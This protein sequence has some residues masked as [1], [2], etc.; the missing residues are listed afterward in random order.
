MKNAVKK[1]SHSEI[2]ALLSAVMI[3]VGMVISIVSAKSSYAIDTIGG[4]VACAVIGIVVCTAVVFLSMKGCP[5]VYIDLLNLIIVV[6]V[7]IA[8]VLMIVGRADLIGFMWFSELM[9]GNPRADLAMNTAIAS[10]VFYAL[11]VL[12][13]IIFGFLKESDN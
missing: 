4:V 9:S 13:Q 1:F 8:L 6:A 11:A 12:I 3:V 10:W 5:R 7:A 2:A